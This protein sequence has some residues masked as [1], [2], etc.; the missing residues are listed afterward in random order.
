MSPKRSNKSSIFDQ[1]NQTVGHQVNIAG[2]DYQTNNITMGANQEDVFAQVLEFIATSNLANN[3]KNE[4]TEKIKGVK[5]EITKGDGANSGLLKTLLKGIVE[6]IPEIAT[7]LL[8][9]IL[10][11]AAGAAAGIKMIAEQILKTA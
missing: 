10:H 1:S 11:P 2:E 7:V 8:T 3:Q 4:V 5:Q 9:A 6:Q